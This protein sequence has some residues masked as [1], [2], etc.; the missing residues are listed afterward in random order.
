MYLKHCISFAA[1]KLLELKSHTW[2]IILSASREWRMG[3]M[4][5]AAALQ[6][7][8]IW[9]KIIDLSSPIGAGQLV[10]H[11]YSQIVALIRYI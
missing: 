6:R 1:L 4:S 5:D 2:W 9:E 8:H 11:G 7:L 3:R 10:W